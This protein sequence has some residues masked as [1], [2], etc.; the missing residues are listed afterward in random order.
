MEFVTHTNNV[1][2]ALKADPI[3]VGP[4]PDVE[5]GA[6]NKPETKNGIDDVNFKIQDKSESDE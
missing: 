2:V 3:E 1:D 4:D 5:M 6:I